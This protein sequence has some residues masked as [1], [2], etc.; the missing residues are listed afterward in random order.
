MCTEKQYAT[1]K[2]VCLVSEVYIVFDQVDPSC[3]RVEEEEGQDVEMEVDRK[4]GVERDCGDLARV[5]DRGCRGR[6]HLF[7]AQSE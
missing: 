7:T 4:R 2:S 5:L 6:S 1:D 3:Q